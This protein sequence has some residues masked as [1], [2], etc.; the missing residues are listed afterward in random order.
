MCIAIENGN[1]LKARFFFGGGGGGGNDWEIFVEKTER[2]EQ[3]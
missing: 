1:K 2:R 3:S